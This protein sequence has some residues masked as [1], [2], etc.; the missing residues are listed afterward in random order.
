MGGQQGLLHTCQGDAEH[1]GATQ[2]SLYL[3]LCPI[4][5]KLLHPTC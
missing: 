4:Q 5:A 1:M 3:R 2:Q